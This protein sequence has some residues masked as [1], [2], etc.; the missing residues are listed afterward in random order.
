MSSRSISITNRRYKTN[1]D[2][3]PERPLQI[4]ILCDYFPDSHSERFLLSVIL[5]AVRRSAESKD[6]LSF[7]VLIARKT[8]SDSA[9]SIPDS[10]FP[11]PCGDY[12][13]DLRPPPG[14]VRH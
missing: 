9:F 7:F 11:V 5:C 13:R 10:L 3:H 2:C 8:R 6:L 1:Y 14:F 12:P 4:V